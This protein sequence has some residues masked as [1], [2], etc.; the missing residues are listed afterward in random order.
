MKILHN[1][2]K[3]KATILEQ[4]DMVPLNTLFAENVVNQMINGTIFVDNTENPRITG[5]PLKG[6][7]KGIWRYRVGDYR[8]LC[9]IQDKKLVI[10]ALELGNRKEIYKK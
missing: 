9:D 3:H 7:K 10:L 8:I 1:I 2:Q 6:N 4:L 5:K